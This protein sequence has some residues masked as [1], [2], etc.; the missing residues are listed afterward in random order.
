MPL[1]ICKYGQFTAA[2]SEAVLPR[3]LHTDRRDHDK[4]GYYAGTGAA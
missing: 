2:R 3:R 4:Y 1:W